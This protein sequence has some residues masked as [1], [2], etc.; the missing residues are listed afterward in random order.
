MK[1]QGF[2][3]RLLCKQFGEKSADMVSGCTISVGNKRSGLVGCIYNR[4]NAGNSLATH[5]RKFWEVD[6]L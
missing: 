5:K 6:D 3:I 2:L 4:E 1:T